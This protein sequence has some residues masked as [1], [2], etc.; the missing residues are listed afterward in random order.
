MSEHSG[1]RERP[2]DAPA[3]PAA[4]A[5]NDARAAD[6]PAPSATPAGPRPEPLRFFGT[7]WLR[8]DGG[9]AARR[10]AAATVS[11]LAAVAGC[12]ILRFA[13]QGLTIAAVSSFVSVLT[14]VMFA[15][16][17]ALAFRRTWQGFVKRPEPD[18]QDAFRGLLAFGFIG[19]LLAYS[20]R[21]LV[22][23]P[24]EGLRRAEYEEALVQYE[25]R[26]SRRTG[27]P[28]RKRPKG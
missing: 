13:F 21:C 20:V 22:E 2:T 18:A 10:T 16:C 8:H 28:A 5:T 27:N 15:I 7:T 3:T 12:L 26:G 14:V 19:S 24:G 6:P 25:R 9:Y 11:L 17:G 4:P 1:T 23:A